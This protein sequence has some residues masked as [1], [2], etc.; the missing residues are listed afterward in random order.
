M[1]EIASKSGFSDDVLREAAASSIINARVTVKEIFSSDQFANSL[2]ENMEYLS[3]MGLD[4]K[5][6]LP[7]LFLNGKIINHDVKKKKFI[8]I[9]ILNF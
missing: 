7:V 5:F 2:D 9:F 3:N 4:S 6:K 8:L 1:H